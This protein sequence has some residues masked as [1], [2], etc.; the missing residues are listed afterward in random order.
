[1]YLYAKKVLKFNKLILT[2]RTLS[3]LV[4]AGNL[5]EHDIDVLMPKWE[6]IKNWFEIT[7]DHEQFQAIFL[8]TGVPHIVVEV[9][10]IKDEIVTLKLVKVLRYFSLAGAKGTNVTFYHLGNDNVINAVTFERGVEGFTKSCGTGAVAAALAFLQKQSK[11]ESEKEIG[12]HELKLKVP[13]GEL[14][15]KINFENQSAHLIGE[16]HINYEIHKEVIQL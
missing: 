11:S 15:V 12:D 3:G 4:S 8:N 16:A 13:G 9:T 6:V 2:F 14:K 1:M 5:K 10:N 7:I